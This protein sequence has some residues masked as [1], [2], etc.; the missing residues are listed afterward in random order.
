MN[1]D[2]TNAGG[3]YKSKGRRHVL[4]EIYP[5]LPPELREVL[6]A[7]LDNLKAAPARDSG[8]YIREAHRPAHTLDE[9]KRA[10]ANAPRSRTPFNSRFSRR[11]GAG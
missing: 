9:L 5:H 1:E 6:V 4:E 8:L 7:R 3:Y 11:S 10:L 2:A